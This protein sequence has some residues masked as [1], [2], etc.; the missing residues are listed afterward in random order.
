[1]QEGNDFLNVEINLISNDF[2]NVEI[3]LI[4]VE[5]RVMVDNIC[6]M[7]V[8]GHQTMLEKISLTWRAAFYEYTLKIVW[9]YEDEFYASWKSYSAAHPVETAVRPKGED[10]ET[11]RLLS[12]L[13]GDD[14][15]GPAPLGAAAAA[16][17]A[18]RF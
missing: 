16:P 8:Y 17:A 1:M 5:I 13:M 4:S 11:E 14:D 7:S 6:Y 12:V 10:S 9:D 18:A 3:N 2:L 15:D